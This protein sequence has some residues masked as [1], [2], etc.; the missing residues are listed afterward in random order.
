MAAPSIALP[1]RR[2]ERASATEK[3][4]TPPRSTPR[5]SAPRTRSRQPPLQRLSKY[6]L[7]KKHAAEPEKNNDCRA[8]AA[9]VHTGWCTA[10]KLGPRQHRTAREAA[11]EEV[12]SRSSCSNGQALRGEIAQEKASYSGVVRRPAQRSLFCTRSL[13]AWLRQPPARSSHRHDRQEEGRR[14][15]P[16]RWRRRP[17][18]VPGSRSGDLGAARHGGDPRLPGQTASRRSPTRPASPRRS[19]R[20]PER[21]ANPHARAGARSSAPEDL[22]AKFNDAAD[23]IRR[24][25]EKPSAT[26][27]RSPCR[28]RGPPAGEKADAHPARQAGRRGRQAPAPSKPPRSALAAIS[29]HPPSLNTA[30]IQGARSGRSSRDRRSVA[31]AQA[32][33]AAARRQ[34]SSIG[35]DLR[36][37]G[38]RLRIAEAAA[39]TAQGPQRPRAP[40]ASAAGGVDTTVS[41]DKI[42]LADRPHQVPS[43]TSREGRGQGRQPDWANDE[44]VRQASAEA[45]EQ[46]ALVKT[47]PALIE[48][49]DDN[50]SPRPR[51]RVPRLNRNHQPRLRV[52]EKGRQ[53]RQPETDEADKLLA[54]RKKAQEKWGSLGGRRP[55]GVVVPRRALLDRSSPSGV[56]G[57]RGAF[58]DPG[59]PPARNSTRSGKLLVRPERSTTEGPSTAARSRAPAQEG[60]VRPGR[61]RH[62]RPRPRPA[63]RSSSAARRS[64]SPS[65]QRRDRTSSPRRWPKIIEKNNSTGR[66][67]K[68]ATRA[69]RLTIARHRRPARLRSALGFLPKAM[70][71]RALT[72]AR[73][74]RRGPRRRLPPDVK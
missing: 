13:D 71:G 14:V 63:D 15:K 46:I 23:L 9:L 74:S 50:D 43:R 4:L 60:R 6:A 36:R 37:A 67:Q 28:G 58:A 5:D 1:P 39:W 2:R 38:D 65:C 61:R 72:S 47:L 41:T 54:D 55:S 40:P 3:K 25:D 17:K 32:R 51:R 48:A 16:D 64:A 35:P 68:R 24:A 21:R 19:S 18:S 29:G 56:P 26:S 53:G 20:S 12:V 66:G 44:A 7:V 70:H 11:Y 69:R 27:P 57:Q 52:R 33:R 42:K 22:P 59:P 31:R 49:L 10:R 73:P 8:A 45:L 30:D 62:R 34:P